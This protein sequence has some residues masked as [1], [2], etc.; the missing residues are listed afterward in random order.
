[1]PVDD[2]ATHFDIPND[3]YT[4]DLTHLVAMIPSYIVS[5]ETKLVISLALSFI[6]WNDIEVKDITDD[7]AEQ[8]KCAEVHEYVDSVISARED[9]AH[10]VPTEYMAAAAAGL[11]AIFVLAFLSWRR[12]I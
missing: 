5:D 7:P 2:D 11:A 3:G 8:Y 6:G 9:T 10:S 1:M 12:I 4:L